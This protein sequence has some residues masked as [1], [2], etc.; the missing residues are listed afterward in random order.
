MY[1]VNMSE[2]E[3]SRS[4]IYKYQRA[5]Q[6]HLS[7]LIRPPKVCVQKG[8]LLLDIMEDPVSDTTTTTSRLLEGEGVE[9]A[10]KDFY[11]KRE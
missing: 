7:T 6:R 11:Q 1:N 9:G 5:I 10:Q 8:K 3:K 4:H 2:L